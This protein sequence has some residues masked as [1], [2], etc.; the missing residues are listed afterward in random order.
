MTIDYYL[1]F[2]SL[3]MCLMLLL[4]VLLV[5]S[6]PQFSFLI[7]QFE[8]FPFFLFNKNKKGEKP[9]ENIVNCLVVVVAVLVFP[10]TAACFPFIKGT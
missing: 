5:F 7:P 6:A 2:K 9:A 8:V 4:F 3:C 1:R 10:T